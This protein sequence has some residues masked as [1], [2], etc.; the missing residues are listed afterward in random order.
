MQKT[1]TI[2]WAIFLSVIFFIDG[3]EIEEE[4]ETVEKEIIINGKNV[5]RRKKHYK[6]KNSYGLFQQTTKSREFSSTKINN[7]LS[8]VKKFS[9]RRRRRTFPMRPKRHHIII[10]S[11]N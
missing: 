10:T 5:S 3:L 1:L 9:P 11:K 8:F 2:A 7:Q 4:L 6:N